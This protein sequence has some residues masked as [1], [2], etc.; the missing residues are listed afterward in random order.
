M[1]TGGD[2]VKPTC[3]LGRTKVAVRGHNVLGGDVMTRKKVIEMCM[4]SPLYFTM[5]LRM[6]LELIKRRERS[7]HG[8]GLREDMLNWVKTGYFTS[9]ARDK[10]RHS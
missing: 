9:S 2:A 6:R 1:V 8:S 5:P 7:H 4:E 10:N 3:H